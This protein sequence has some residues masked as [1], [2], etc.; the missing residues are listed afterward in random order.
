[1]NDAAIVAHISQLPHARA[2]FKQLLRELGSQR[3]RQ[4]Q[5]PIHE[6]E[7]QAYLFGSIADAFSYLAAFASDLAPKQFGGA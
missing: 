1:M 7:G 4:A 2:N 3:I 5:E 6:A